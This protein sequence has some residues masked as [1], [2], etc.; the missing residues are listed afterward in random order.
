MTPKE[1]AIKEA[2]GAH[3]DV[4]KKFTDEDGWIETS[5]QSPYLNIGNWGIDNPPPIKNILGGNDY[6]G[7]REYFGK[8][9]PIILTGIEH[10]NGWVKIESEA[11][12]PTTEVS[13][14]V[15]SKVNWGIGYRIDIFTG[16]LSN[17]IDHETGKPIFS[18]YQ[19]IIK[20]KPPIY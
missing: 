16:R 11:D 13:Y 17:T 19:P 7:I 3:W 14:F 20:P 18:H 2:Y 15:Y 9:R 12:L 4:A 6:E 8:W 1:Q 10:N 5:K